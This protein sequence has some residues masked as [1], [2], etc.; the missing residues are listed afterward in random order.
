[1]IQKIIHPLVFA[2]MLLVAP[3]ADAKKYEKSDERVAMNAALRELPTFFKSGAFY[4][5]WDLPS[6]KSIVDQ[7]WSELTDK[8]P[9]LLEKELS[10]WLPTAPDKAEISRRDAETTRLVGRYKARSAIA[11]RKKAE[12]ATRKAT[13]NEIQTLPKNFS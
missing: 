1:M 13:L 11:T 10:Q 8:H 12:E 6:T 9:E 7:I 3:T 2:G 5:K 4:S